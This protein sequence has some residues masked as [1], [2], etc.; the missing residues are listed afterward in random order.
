MWGEI[1]ETSVGIMHMSVSQS[2]GR[3]VLLSGDSNPCP[4]VDKGSAAEEGVTQGSQP[5]SSLFYEQQKTV[6]QACVLECIH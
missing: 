3:V 1:K 4:T 2:V 5:H 6:M